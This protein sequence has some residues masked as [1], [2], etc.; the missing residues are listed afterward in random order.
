MP[1]TVYNRICEG[2]YMS[3]QV[4][5]YNRQKDFT[6]VGDFLIDIYRPGELPANWLQPRWEYMHYLCLPLYEVD[7]LDL[8]KIGIFEDSGNI[9]GVVHFEDRLG[10][11]YFETH[12]DY[13]HL[14]L[15]MLNYAENHLYAKLGN[16]RRYVRAFIN[17]FD[18]EFESIAQSR[19]YKKDT[20]SPIYTS[21][22]SI[23]D[24]FP[25]IILPDGFCLKS[26]EDDNDLYKINR[27]LHRGFNH[28]GEPREEDIKFRKSIQSAPNF[29]K[30]LTIVVEAPHGDFVSFCGMW[31]VKPHKIAYVE[32]VATDPDYR[33]MGLGKAA[34]LEGIRRCGELGATVAFVGSGRAFYE[35]IGFKKMFA[36]YPWIRYF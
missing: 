11:T 24:P 27:V 9:V 12:P 4:R 10:D 33:F 3:V 2:E 20:D 6:L 17:D 36:Y 34:V 7:Q 32:P 23:S 30:D 14:K 18:S 15:E 5:S 29:R 16:G 22:F 21:Q 31:F 8:E 19:G 13:T 28:P 26:L 1:N 35:A 25:P